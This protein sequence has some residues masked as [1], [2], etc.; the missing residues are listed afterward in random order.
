[1]MRHF[2]S[3]SMFHYSCISA[4][5][6]IKGFRLD[7]SDRRGFTHFV[8]H[9][10]ET[11]SSDSK[12]SGLSIFKQ[13]QYKAAARTEVAVSRAMDGTAVLAPATIK[14]GQPIGTKPY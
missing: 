1:M 12:V 4:Q 14:N 5:V 3:V 9:C 6:E 8:D 2:S 10:C 7:W 11:H 13:R